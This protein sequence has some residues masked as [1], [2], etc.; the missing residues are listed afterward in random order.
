MGL[1]SKLTALLMTL[2][3]ML[4][5]GACQQIRE[6][7]YLMEVTVEVTTI[8]VVTTTPHETGTEVAQ[9]EATSTPLPTATASPPPEE[10]ASTT[11]DA[12]P[13][14]IIEPIIVAEQLFERGR[15]YYIQPLE[16]I[17]VLIHDDNDGRSGVW[18]IYEDTWRDGLPEID[19]SI[20]PPEGF[21]QPIRG[22]GKLWRENT[23][24]RDELGWALDDEYG[25]WVDY[26][27]EYGGI[28][29]EN[30]DYV[31]GPGFHRFSGRDGVFLEFNEL[32]GSWQLI[33][34]SET[35]DS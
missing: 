26:V 35:S 9:A 7:Q 21:L 32:D 1:A 18:A 29:D 30:G 6:T 8:V 33:V 31:A 13:A 20:E 23:M 22:F 12:I 28:L 4:M 2:G 10:T 24:V 14:P 15:M 27:Y 25:F 5:V 11:E 34:R 16:Q 3:M 19:P 17:W